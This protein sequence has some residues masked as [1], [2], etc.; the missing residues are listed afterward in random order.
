MRIHIQKKSYFFSFLLS[1]FQSFTK[2]TME[3][4]EKCNKVLLIADVSLSAAII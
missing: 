4:F 1:Y 3:H 2:T